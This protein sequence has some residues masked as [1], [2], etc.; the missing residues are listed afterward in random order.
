MSTTQGQTK[1]VFMDFFF[2][3]PYGRQHSEKYAYNTV[4]LFNKVRHKD[5][6]ELLGKIDLFRKDTRIIQRFYCK[7]N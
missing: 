5:L 3:K 4:F 7:M 1:R 6:F 2:T